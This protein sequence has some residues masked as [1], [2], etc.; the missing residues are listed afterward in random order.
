[1]L[2]RIHF[3]K[4]LTGACAVGLSSIYLA[5]LPEVVRAEQ[6]KDKDSLI[7]PTR[8]IGG[9]TRRDS[10]AVNQE[11]LIALIPANSVGMTTSLYP[12]FFFYLP[13]TNQSRTVEFVLRNQQDELVYEANFDTVGKSGVV[14][15]DLPTENEPLL[16][17]QDYHWYLSLICDPEN[18]AQDLVVEGIIRR[19]ELEPVAASQLN[20]LKPI[21]KVDFYLQAN[22]WYEAI[23]T[24]AQLK[25]GSAHQAELSVK[26]TNL[27]HSVGLEQISDQPIIAAYR[28]SV[29]NRQILSSALTPEQLG[30]RQSKGKAV[31][32]FQEL[33][34]LSYGIT[35][36]AI[37]I[38]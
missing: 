16:L 19:T 26:W 4:A 5:S 27:L 22:L 25:R 37:T 11:S 31:H 14:S 15:L 32:S 6:Q 30:L 2:K 38:R 1:M 8:R 3:G 35:E 12:T 20:Q 24:L 10:C 34:R 9:G 17:N 36:P 13:Q 21:E 23:A 29:P 28:S 7:M 18:R 33:E